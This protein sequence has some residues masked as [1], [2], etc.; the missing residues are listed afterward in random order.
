MQTP[1]RHRTL[2]AL[3]WL[4]SLPCVITLICEVAIRVHVVATHNRLDAV[5]TFGVFGMLLLLILSFFT[6]I[7]ASAIA[8]YLLVSRNS[9]LI[10]QVHALLVAVNGWVLLYFT[11][12]FAQT[13]G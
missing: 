3:V 9:T 7:V 5:T 6:E 10:T 11:L 8:I 12:Q 1:P 2:L 4:F 13:I